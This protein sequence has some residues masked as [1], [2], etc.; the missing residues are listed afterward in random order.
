MCTQKRGGVCF[1]KYY[2]K[3]RK[4]SKPHTYP[5][6]AKLAKKIVS[7]SSQLACHETSPF[8][9]KRV[10]KIFIKNVGPIC[11]FWNDFS[12]SRQACKNHL[13]LRSKNSK[14]SHFLKINFPYPRKLQFPWNLGNLKRKCC[15]KSWC[16][17][18]FGAFC[19][20]GIIPSRR[21][22]AP[23]EGTNSPRLFTPGETKPLAESKVHQISRAW[24]TN[25]GWSSSL[26]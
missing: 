17:N 18:Y 3:R 15:S 6:F 4:L 5:R 24:V 14:L 11:N 21:R 25:D 13:F 1:L 9:F 23:C 7:H 8:V 22:E 26:I 12:M 10:Y 19:Y 2:F 20:R 16:K